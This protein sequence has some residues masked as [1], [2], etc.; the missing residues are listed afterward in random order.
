MV[1]QIMLH[2]DRAGSFHRCVRKA[3][4]KGGG[5]GEILK[6]LIF[7][8]GEVVTLKGRELEAVQK[9]L[10]KGALVEVEK[11]DRNKWRPKQVAKEEE[12]TVTI[13]KSEYEALLECAANAREMKDA[14][15]AEGA[16]EAIAAG[17]NGNGEH[18]Q[19]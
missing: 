6:T 15:K 16:R 17:S 3:P 10:A 8:P 19:G 14:A 9:D 11:D 7:E 4:P 12:E 2:P 13:P 18:A 5:K 1:L